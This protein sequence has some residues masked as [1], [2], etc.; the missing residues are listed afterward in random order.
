MF[1]DDSVG[2]SSNHHV[3]SDEQTVGIRLI[4]RC[5]HTAGGLNSLVDLFQAQEKTACLQDD[6][7]A[8]AM[9]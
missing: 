7:S 5:V 9:R 2:S 4:T 3:A 1:V 6:E 8:K